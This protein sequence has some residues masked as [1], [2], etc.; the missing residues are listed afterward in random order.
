MDWSA[1]DRHKGRV[2]VS[3]SGGKDST[4]VL[5]MM[6]EAGLL[7]RA[8]VYHLDTGDLFPEML[9]HVA[10]VS[11]WCPRFV[12]VQTDARAWAREHGDPT[13]LLPH[14]SHLIGQSMREGRKLS[15]R[16]D[17]C[18][19]NLMG[20]LYARMKEDGI[21]LT[22]RGTRRDDMKHVPVADGETLD[23]MEVLAPLENWT[24]AKVFAFIAKHEIPIPAFYEHF[25]QGP[26]CMTCP[27]WWHVDAGPY[28]KERHPAAF[29][30]YEGRVNN[31]MREVAPCLQNLK[32]LLAAFEERTA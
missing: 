13:D 31:V 6:R 4:V 9:D 20:P 19:A 24:E 25:R 28:L 5:W 29:G 15:A 2:A 30:A 12:T 18:F 22:V 21:T 27:A 3:F 32:K 8:T 17:C 16:Y 11:N 23:G 26:E 14:S 10:E 7:D 1:I